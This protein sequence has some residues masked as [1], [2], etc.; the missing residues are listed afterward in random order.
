MEGALAQGQ[1]GQLSAVA[2]CCGFAQLSAQDRALQKA[3]VA[4]DDDDLEDDLEDIMA[5]LKV[6]RVSVAVLLY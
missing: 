1:E 5:S 2:A 6:C 3:R 4:W